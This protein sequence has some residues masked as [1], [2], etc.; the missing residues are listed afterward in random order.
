MLIFVKMDW[1]LPIGRALAVVIAS[2]SLSGCMTVQ[3]KLAED[4]Q[5]GHP[6]SGISGDAYFIWCSWGS[7]QIAKEKDGTSYLVSLPLVVLIDLM[8]LI[9]APFSLVGD[10]LLLPLDIVKEPVRERWNPFTKP[11]RKPA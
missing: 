4:T 6:Y 8:L 9:D 7:P 3:S 5:I 11:C 10:T 2:L 1:T